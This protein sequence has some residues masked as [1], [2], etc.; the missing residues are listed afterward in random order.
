MFDWYILIPLILGPMSMAMVTIIVVAI[1][2]ARQRRTELQAEVQEKLIDRFGS[3]PELIAFLK[4]PEGRKFLGDIES[5]PKLN[6]RDR[7]IRGMGKSII[8]GLL[9]VGFLIIGFLPTTA[10]D[11]CVVTGFLLIALGL[12]FFLSALLSLKLSRNW[13]LMDEDAPQAN[14]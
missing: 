14:A 8:T 10:N 4:S 7:I 5:G 3:A 11:F 12:G 6:A 13:G 1:A 9:G 2:R